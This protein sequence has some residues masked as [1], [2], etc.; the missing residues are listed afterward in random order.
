MRSWLRV[1]IKVEADGGVLGDVHFV[2]C[3][4][5]ISLRLERKIGSTCTY[6]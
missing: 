3:V 4:S 2:A 1:R 5:C 6:S